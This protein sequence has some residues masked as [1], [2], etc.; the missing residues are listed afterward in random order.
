MWFIIFTFLYQF[1][2][3]DTL[4]SRT[5]FF[6]IFIPMNG[7]KKLLLS[8]LGEKR[9]LQLLSSSF[10]LLY[11][12]VGMGVD[13]QDIYFLKEYVQTGDYCADIGAHLG[14]YTMELSGLVKQDGRVIA[15]EP[16]TKFFTTLRGLVE[17]QKA[18]NVILHQLAMGGDSDFV[19]MGIPEVNN[20]KK[21]A[22]ARIKKSNELL[23]YVETEKV[24]NEAGDRLFL[25]LPRLDFIKCDV[26]GLEISVFSAMMQT[27]ARFRP[28]L[29]CE[30]ADKN[31]RKK[32]SDMLAPYGY[33]T[34][35]LENK[36]L[37][38]ADA[39]PEK[40]AVS[41]NHYFI[42]A[43]RENRLKVFIAS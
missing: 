11:K 14:Y 37:F 39:H 12:T 21:F 7:L 16:M 10:Q 33:K 42:P 35:I 5:Q 6:R 31:E 3:S 40:K 8:L 34:Y 9:Y 41:H 43:V 1:K 28:I 2:L 22:Y 32:L 19:E 38:L 23:D 29:L 25:D 27:V 17:K 18:A 36:K 13:Y 30:L 4:K 20:V 15:I 24:R 26:E